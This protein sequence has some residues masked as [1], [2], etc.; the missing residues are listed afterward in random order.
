MMVRRAAMIW[1]MHSLAYVAGLVLSGVVAV[2]LWTIVP[3]TGPTWMLFGLTLAVSIV[4]VGAGYGLYLT[5][6][7]LLLDIELGWSYYLLGPVIVLGVMG[8]VFGLVFLHVLTV[9]QGSVAGYV[10]LFL[11][12]GL[13]MMRRAIPSEAD[14][15]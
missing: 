11:A 4:A 8:L 5:L 1:L 7:G 15:T 6:V 9:G 12:G 13:S 10:L 2:G 3:V 14:E